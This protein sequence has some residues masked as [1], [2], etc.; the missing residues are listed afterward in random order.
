M[1]ARVLQLVDR[2]LVLRREIA[3]REEELKVVE[4]NLVNFAQ[5]GEQAPLVDEDREG[6]Q[7]LARGSK[8]IVP[9]V[10][11]ADKIVGSFKDGAALQTQLRT[12]AGDNLKWFYAPTRQWKMV[13]KNGKMFRF[14][15]GRMLGPAGPAFITACLD[16]DKHG[17]PKSDIKIDWE[18]A[19][20]IPAG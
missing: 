8:V 10:F 18:R 14:E 17:I 11:T 15:A 12:L 2:G 6:K 3:E 20:E 4:S 1:I 16:R 7:F 19:K 5:D 9:V 13:P